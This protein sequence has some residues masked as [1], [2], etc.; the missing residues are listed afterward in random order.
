MIKRRKTRTV[1]VG[2]VKIGSGHPVSV[3]SMTKTDT[4]DVEATVRQ[5]RDLEKAGCEIVRVAVKGAE[6]AKAILPIKKK[7]RIP[8]VADIHFDWRLAIEAINQGADKIRINPGNINSPEEIEKVIDSAAEKNIPIRIG[9]NS[10]SLPEECSGRDI[11]DGMVSAAMK[12]LKLFAKKKF[13][14]IVLS[15]K[16]SDVFT[17]VKAYRKM[18]EKCDYPMHLG[19]TATGLPG[20]GVVKSSAGI[21][22]LLLDG[23]G[24]TVR[25]SLTGDP[26]QEVDAARR[27]LASVGARN[28]G[29]EIIACPTCGRC[30][31]DLISIVKQ[32]E[33]EIRNTKYEIRNTDKQLIVAVM[34]CEVN[35]PGEAK[36]ADIGIAFGKGKGV[37][38][39]H[40]QVIRTV[41]ADASVRELVAMIAEEI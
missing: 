40:G 23:I 34:G 17:T 8:L 29:P 13:H 18:S 6:D 25:V 1:T 37:I 2:D 38:F 14:N 16:A 20:Q 9:V 19:V 35:G 15:L 33:E 36:D 7:I 39:R 26:V 5:V 41:E 28:F 12:F 30:Q 24:D 3:Q 27:I 10:G 4:S 11:A 21:G 31:V 32:L 22:A